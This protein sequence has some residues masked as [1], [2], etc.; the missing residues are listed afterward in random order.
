MNNAAEQITG[1]KLEEL[2]DYT[3][4][5]SCHSCKRDGS[6][7]PIHECP[8]FHAQQTGTSVKDASEVFVHKS[9]HFYDIVFSVSP[10]GEYGSSGS[11]IEFRDVS[12]QRRIEKERLEA[13][14][15]SQQTALMLK[16]TESHKEAMSS[17]IS[18]ICHELRNPLQGI[19]ASAEFLLESVSQLKKDLADD[20][21]QNADSK[22]WPPTVTLIEGRDSKYSNKLDKVEKMLEDAQ[23]LI[24]N[25]QT[26][27]DHQALI[28]N[29]TLDL[30]RLEAGKAEPSL[31]IIDILAVG[32]QCIT[33]M[34]AKAHAK[35][36]SL[37]LADPDRLPLYIFG[38]AT[39]LTQVILNLISNAVKFTLRDGTIILNLHISS[40][41][42]DSNPKSR[43][44]TLH[45]SVQDNG[46]GMTE[47]EKGRLFQRFSQGNKKVAQL[48]GGSG[49]G[50]NISRELV[51]VMGGSMEVESARGVGSTFRFTT[52]HTV[53][54]DL[55]MHRFLSRSTGSIATTPIDENRSLNS[56]LGAM[57][58]NETPISESGANGTHT[59]LPTEVIPASSSEPAPHFKFVGVAEDNPI[60]LSYLAKVLK[61]L[62]Y[63]H[64]LC[65]NGEELLTQFLEPDSLIDVIIADMHMP[66][67]DGLELTRLV[68]EI[69]TTRNLKSGG[70]GMSNGTSQ[71]A[72]NHQGIPIIALS[73]NALTEQV[74]E[75]FEAGVSDYLLKPTKKANLVKTLQYW[76]DIVHKG[77]LHQPMAES[78]R[79]IAK[80]VIR[81][82]ARAGSLGG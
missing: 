67:L 22:N 73:G 57:A 74:A 21:H 34:T 54:S 2:F 39:M 27:A 72:N 62:G 1:F 49:L 77:G 18:F 52:V 17:F 5:A 26:C 50:L 11:V 31:E 64:V 30:S 29:N 13:I 43:K 80:G 25:I 19:T 23:S 41:S 28:I 65:T 8:V 33:M 61:G 66:V 44:I 71:Q 58:M 10:V 48:Y 37:K 12:D 24:A 51:R 56:A 47:T 4:H 40:T 35:S 53:P 20:K 14:L 7:Y 68:R 3:F 79:T 81:K 60:N 45:G 63:D 82:P 9:G 75:A 42:S 70:E 76:E 15:E 16:S 78:V 6:P 38:D 36:V 46:I 59:T 32:A 55:E 69:E